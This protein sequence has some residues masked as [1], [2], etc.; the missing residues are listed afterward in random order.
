M[1]KNSVKNQQAE[2]KKENPESE[3]SKGDLPE[4]LLYES[5]TS[6]FKELVKI[7]AIFLGIITTVAIFATVK[8]RNEMRAEIT[9]LAEDGKIAISETQKIVNEKLN[10]IQR[11]ASELALKEAEKRINEILKKSNI[12]DLTEK[13]VKKYAV[14]KIEKE[15]Q[16][17]IDVTLKSIQEEIS[18]LGV[19]ADSAIKMRIGHKSGLVKMLEIIKNEKNQIVKRR[20]QDLLDNIS[21]DY[22][23][24]SLRYIDAWNI[25]NYVKAGLAT[26]S[27]DLNQKKAQLIKM[28]EKE[29]DLNNVAILFQNLRKN[30]ETNLKM[31]DFDAIAS[32]SKKIKE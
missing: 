13:A 21:S 31:F 1:S 19:I 6:Y 24:F 2:Q 7:S 18:S 32:I 27:K 14:E 28:I 11:Q 17:E 16:K 10:N 12:E 29:E 25:D 22:D 26:E 30:G 4:K 5:L 15:V 8:D 9:K 23:A 20:A 3:E